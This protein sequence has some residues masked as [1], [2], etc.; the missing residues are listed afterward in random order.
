M[1]RSIS[2]RSLQSHCIENMTRYSRTC[3][4]RC[5]LGYRIAFSHVAHDKAAISA[6]LR[7][8]FANLPPAHLFH[9]PSEVEL[10]LNYYLTMG[11]RFLSQAPQPANNF[12]IALILPLYWSCL[13][14][15]L[16]SPS[17]ANAAKNSFSSILLPAK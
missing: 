7:T 17:P 16:S 5:R 13:I 9:N 6:S 3:A 14:S 8:Y 12:K 4:D 1:V 10:P 15:T 11:G 2:I